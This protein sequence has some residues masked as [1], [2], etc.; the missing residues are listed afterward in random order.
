MSATVFDA[1]AHCSGYRKMWGTGVQCNLLK[2]I[3]S[4]PIDLPTAVHYPIILNLQPAFA[5]LNKP[6]G[7]FPV[8]EEMAMW[9]MSL[10]MGPDLPL[11]EQERI[12][13]AL[14]A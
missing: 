6:E 2:S 8:A 1:S 13:T 3:D 12:I 10:P 11:L 7:S 14:C 9:V 4:D 5:Y